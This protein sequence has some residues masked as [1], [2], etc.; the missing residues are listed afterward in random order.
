MKYL[1]TDEINNLGLR[2][3][4]AMRDIPYHYV[5]IND[6]GGWVESEKNLSQEGDCWI[7]DNAMV[8]EN[9]RVEGDAVVYE[10]AYIHGNTVI[11]DKAEVCGETELCSNIVING[12]AFLD[13]TIIVDDY[14]RLHNDIC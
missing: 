4:I 5:K 7:D 6:L 14:T 2:R 9:A 11:K 1:L 13:D 10:N 3:V 12:R 8:F